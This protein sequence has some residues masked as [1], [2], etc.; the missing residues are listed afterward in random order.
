[1]TKE[2][3]QEELDGLLIL[4]GSSTVNR[5]TAIAGQLKQR[6]QQEQPPKAEAPQDE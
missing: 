3:L 6:L 5:I 1:M 4:V 2:E